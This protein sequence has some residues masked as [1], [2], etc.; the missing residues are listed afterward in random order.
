M[1]NHLHPGRQA[2]AIVNVLVEI[3]KG[4]SNKYEYDSRRG[5]FVLDRVLYSPLFYPCEYGLIA[6]TLGGDGDPLDA[7]VLSTFPTFTGCLIPA[8]VVGALRMRDEHGSDFR[9]LAAC[10]CDPRYAGTRELDDVPG[11]I[12]REI[13]CFF[14]S[15]KQLEEKSVEIY[16]WVG[17]GQACKEITRAIAR[18]QRATSVERSR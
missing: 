9:V 2:P 12:R 7:L 17:R 10:A 13:A 16:G 4:G 11:H 15:Y 5:V 1:G 6:G 18:A 3:P 14:E 8:R